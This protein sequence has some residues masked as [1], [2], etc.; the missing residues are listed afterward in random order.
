MLL[1]WCSTAM[2]STASQQL[3]LYGSCRASATRTSAWGVCR[4]GMPQGRRRLA[5]TPA[6][7]EGVVA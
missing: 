1:M 6:R 7:P 2:H 5:A 4:D 3:P